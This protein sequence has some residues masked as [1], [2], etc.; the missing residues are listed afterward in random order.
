MKGY[1]LPLCLIGQT[2]GD[3]RIV[4]EEMCNPKCH[5]LTSMEA[6]FCM[7]G[8]LTECHAGMNCNEAE[9]SHLERY[10]DGEDVL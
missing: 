1:P 2:L 8:H 9:C 3:G 6:F 4:T 10:E 5:C 7:E